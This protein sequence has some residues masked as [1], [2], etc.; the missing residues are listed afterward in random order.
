VFL[1]VFAYIDRTAVLLAKLKFKFGVCF[2]RSFLESLS[3]APPPPK[4]AE[5][6][7]ATL[8]MISLGC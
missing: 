6:L 1:R 5:V 2:E 4:L 8:R 3:L 7:T